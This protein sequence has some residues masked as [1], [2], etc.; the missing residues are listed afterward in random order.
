MFPTYS[1]VY[2]HYNILCQ[3]NISD[4]RSKNVKYQQQQKKYNTIQNI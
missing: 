1:V 3:F 4:N 2:K